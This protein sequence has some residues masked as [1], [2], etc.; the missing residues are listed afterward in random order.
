MTPHQSAFILSAFVIAL[1]VLGIT[2]DRLT[3]RL[4]WAG[5]ALCAAVVTAWVWL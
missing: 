4:A 2:S 5:A 1:A 3:A